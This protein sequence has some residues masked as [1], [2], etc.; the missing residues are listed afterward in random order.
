MRTTLLFAVAVFAFPIVH[1]NDEFPEAPDTQEET[2]KPLTPKEAL[3][4]LQLPEGFE[5]TVFAAEPEVRQPIAQAFDARGRLWVAENYTYADRKILHNLELRDRI[6]VFEDK[7]ND[8]RADDRKV[9][10]DD[11]IRLTSVEIGFGGVW[12]LCPPQLLFIPDADEDAVPD[13]DPIVMLDGFETANT[14]HNFANGL[15]W[16]PDG[17]LYGRHGI[18]ASSEVGRPG[19]PR[20]R[21]TVLNC[22]IWRFHPTRFDFEVVASGTTNA[23][24]HDWDE[25]G[26]LFFINTVIGHLWHVVPGAHYERMYGED[27][28]PHVYRLIPQTADH[29]HWDE[30]N[31]N[32]TDLRK[33]GLSEGTNLAGGGHAHSGMMIYLG[34]NWP[35]EYRGDLFT[36]NL[37]GRRANR[38][39]LKR[40]GATYT[41]V[42]RPDVFKSDDLYFRG[43]EISYGPDG[44]VYVL[45]W[46]D[47]GEC[48]ENDG[49]HRSSGRIFKITHG[50]TIRSVPGDLS[51]LSNDDLVHLLS[52]END[53]YPRI[54]RRLLQERAHRGVNIAE[55]T[56]RK[57][58][59]IATDSKNVR[60]QLRGLWTLHAIG[61]I[62]DERLY[63]LLADESE[64]IRLWAVKLLTDAGQPSG[65]TARV[66]QVIA[67][68][69]S[70]GLVLV[71]LASAMDRLA[72]D[73][74]W[75]IAQSIAKRKEFRGDPVLPKMVWYGIEP[76]VAANPRRAVALL[77]SSEFPD[78]RYFIARRITET[79]DE[80]E[81]AVDGLVQYMHGVPDYAGRLD[82]LRGIADA[83]RGWHRAAKPKGWDE[84][85]QTIRQ[86]R[87]DA[88]IG[89]VDQ[90]SIVFGDGRSTDEL[91]KIAR[92]K[93]RFSTAFRR[94]AIQ[95]LVKSKAEGTAALLTNLAQDRDVS[96]A[97]VA[98]LG[99]FPDAAPEILKIFG[100]IHR[101]A[102]ATAVDALV[103]RPASAALLLDA[104]E[105]GSVPKIQISAFQLIRVQLL[106]NEELSERVRKL[107]PE[108]RLLEEDKLAQIEK[109]R[110]LLTI[111]RIK[112]GNLERGK[113]LFTKTCGSCHK[114]FGEG[115][116]IAPELTGAQRDNVDYWLEN[117][118][119]PSAIVPED[120]RLSTVVLQDARVLSG[121]LGARLGRTV[122]LQTPTEKLALDRESIV[123]TTKTAK[124]L[125]PD[126]L[127]STLS[128]EQI[129][130]LFAYLMS[131]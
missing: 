79:L 4:K 28:D 48:H 45:D 51:K 32:W 83:L 92:G 63:R 91:I 30:K 18:L 107:W 17:W 105:K 73:D 27:L 25:F 94:R 116:T 50:R 37:N 117:I 77:S 55:G 57:I 121:V 2:T 111:E 68:A 38:D 130:D 53:W 110:K 80:N 13:G 115:G 86:S 61:E 15:R 89:L 81:G 106:G 114:L 103:A 59:Q 82:T 29:V 66:L 21:R 35:K 40:K 16:G 113:E 123:S 43:I 46:S 120:Y 31:E 100:R 19:T 9:F 71:H 124:S 39:A 11:G 14:R 10:W 44:G 70:D 65:K 24:G 122:E 8:G 42:H 129:V 6:V 102:R 126:A 119:D 64:H 125:M 98:G 20:E 56:I 101:R 87:S 3:A 76:A 95:S 12:A 99:T 104:V 60:H 78:L 90:I 108:L 97:A 74:R 54:A 1:A 109:H 36:L 62:A 72:H 33:K 128:E 75:L 112:T 58:L 7:D 88:A 23:W 26:Q 47:I 5:A 22:S 93:G 85:A 69:E 41:G 84:F 118:F 52:H 49:L 127:L 34:D 96:T 131:R 67:S